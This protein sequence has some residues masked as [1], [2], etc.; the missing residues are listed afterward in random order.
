[1]QSVDGIREV[2]RRRLPRFVFD[3]VDGG[4]GTEATLRE[5]RAALDRVRLIGRAPVN[6]S[7]CTHARK[8]PASSASRFRCRSSSVRPVLP[9]R[10]SRGATWRWLGQ[11]MLQAFRLP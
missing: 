10:S 7:E 4:A 2:A 11:R 3:F 6:M 1:M 5:N 9:A 8:Q